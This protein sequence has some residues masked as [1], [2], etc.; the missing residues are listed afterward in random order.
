MLLVH[1][2][3]HVGC[4]NGHPAAPLIAHSRER[5][6]PPAGIHGQFN[7]KLELL[8]WK[9][10]ILRHISNPRNSRNE[11]SWNSRNM[12]QKSEFLG[13]LPPPTFPPLKG[14]N[15]IRNQKSEF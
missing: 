13:V 4:A 5:P 11:P 12:L 1:L 8:A 9:S 3:G 15:E 10:E 6:R 7:V 14:L 2:V